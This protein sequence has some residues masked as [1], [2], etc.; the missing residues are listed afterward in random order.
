LGAGAAKMECLN[1]KKLVLVGLCNGA[2]YWQNAVH[3]TRM[4]ELFG[5][6]VAKEIKIEFW[7]WESFSDV[8]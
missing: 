3:K 5:N 6:A 1:L 2:T 7:D 4:E 8:S